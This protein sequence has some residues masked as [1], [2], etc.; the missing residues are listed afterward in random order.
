M[1]VIYCYIQENETLSDSRERGELSI[2]SE[3]HVPRPRNHFV[4]RYV[5]IGYSVIEKL[6]DE[7]KACRITGLN[8]CDICAGDSDYTAL[9]VVIDHIDIEKIDLFILSISEPS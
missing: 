3:L 1:P 2:R 4:F 9:T 6:A 5:R 8:I 7:L